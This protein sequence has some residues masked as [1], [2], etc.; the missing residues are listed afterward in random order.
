MLFNPSRYDESSYVR[1]KDCSF[2]LI[3]ITCSYMLLDRY[4][5][6]DMHDFPRWYREDHI[7]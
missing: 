3:K 6:V 4:Q 1:D 2:N 7:S 5:K